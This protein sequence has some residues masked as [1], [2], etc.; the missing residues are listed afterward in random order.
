M[1]LQTNDWTDALPKCTNVIIDCYHSIGEASWLPGTTFLNYLNPASPSTL[2]Y[3]EYGLCST[4]PDARAYPLKNELYCETCRS[5][6]REVR[7]RAHGLRG[8]ARWT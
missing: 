8:S 5:W 3:V 4:H 2:D 6:K 1:A 7:R